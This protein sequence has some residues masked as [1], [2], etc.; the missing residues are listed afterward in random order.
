MDFSVYEVHRYIIA[1]KKLLT[2]K[3]SADLYVAN[4]KR[5]GF[6]KRLSCRTNSRPRPLL[7]PVTSTLYSSII[8]KYFLFKL[9]KE[10]LLSA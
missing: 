5:G 9:L 2:P 7:A 4:I 10:I 6:V 3:D 1:K 8:G